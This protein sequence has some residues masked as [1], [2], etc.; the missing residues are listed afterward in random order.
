M[1]NY[2]FD[3]IVAGGG[4]SGFA[5]AISAA[6]NNTNVL[7]IEELGYLGGAA[8]ATY[9]TPMMKTILPDGTDL[10]GTLYREVL[11]RL[12]DYGFADINFDNNP[13]WFVPEMMKFAL[14]D[15]AE[16][17]RVKVLFHSQVCGASVENGI[18]KSIDILNKSGINEYSAKQFI[19]ATGDATV[20]AYAGVPF[21]VGFNGITQAMSHRFVMGNVDIEKFAG[22]LENYDPDK[23]VSPI[24]RTSSGDILLTTAYTTEDKPWALRSLFMDALVH[25]ILKP[26]DAT[27]FQLFTMPGQKGCVYFNCPRIYSKKPLHPL[28]AEDL[29]YAQIM[30][31]KQIRRYSVFCKKYLPGFEDAY[32]V[33]I[34]ANVGVRDSRRIQGK[35]TLTT[36]DITSSRKFKTAVARCNYPIDVHSSKE[37]EGGLIQLKE[38][39]YYEIPLE[40]LETHEVKNLLVVGKAISAEFKAQASLRVQPT[41]W[42]MGESAGYIAARRALKETSGGSI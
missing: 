17:A 31:R 38:D 36:Q 20:A 39:D 41:C 14:D 28:D 4:T 9:V 11:N 7:I 18:L 10:G 1:S 32:I 5:S 16:E 29:S 26:Y 34:A 12:K 33:N 21:E 3:V 8:T 27:Y 2:N 13:G 37:G 35:Y 24:H 6:R 40:C 19:D 22:W 30:G 42:A 25:N 15:I 23:S